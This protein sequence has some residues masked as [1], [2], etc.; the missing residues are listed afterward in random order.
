MPRYAWVNVASEQSAI[1]KSAIL[2]APRVFC[3]APVMQVPETEVI[4]IGPGGAELLRAVLTPGDYVMGRSAECEL[5]FEADLVSRKHAMLTINFEHALV[6]DLGSSN[7]TFVNGQPIKEC[8][9]LWPNQKIQ[10][11]AATVELHR[12]KTVPPPG[13]S[14]APATAAV[15]RILP[16]E[17]LRDKKYDIGGVVARGGMGAILDAKENSTERKVAMKVMLDGST[18]DDLARFIGEAKVT[19]QLEHPNIVPVHELGVDENDQVF[20]TMK[21]VRGITLRK[22]LELMA[23]GTEAT[24]RKYPLAAMLTIFQKVC[25]AVAFA[26]SKSVI[27]RDLKPENIMLGDFG[28]VLVMDWGL[29][30]LLRRDDL[31]GKATDETMRSKVRP[32]PEAGSDGLG[33]V[34]GSIMGTPQ[35][36]APEQARGEVDA[37]DARTDIY[38]LGAI[39]FHLLYLRSPVSGRSAAEIV[40]KVGKGLLD[41]PDA[42]ASAP[43]KLLHLPNRRV[44]DSLLAVC[45]K[46][47]TVD[48]GGR[49][50]S[51]AALQKDI[52]AYQGGFATSAE[53][54]G[55]GKQLV[56]L[57]KRH[58]ALFGT[59]FAAWLVITALA[60]WFV[61]KITASE[62]QERDTLAQLRATAPTFLDQARVLTGQGKLP[63]A[64]D[65]IG[66]ALTLDPNEAG[67]HAQRGNILQSM[68]RFLEAADAYA[69]A[70]RLNPQ[71]PNAGANI[72]LSCALAEAKDKDGALSLNT[73][74]KWRDA[75]TV[76]GRAAEAILDGRGTGFDAKKML[77]VWQAKIDA[78]L[79]K[80]APRL[81]LDSSGFYNLDL[82]NL[83]LTDL[84]P[85]RGMPLSSLLITG[86]PHLK[87][88]SPLADC[89]LEQLTASQIPDL[90]D[91]SPLKGKKLKTL[92]L[93][94]TGVRN[95]EIL[96]GIKT[97]EQFS[98]SGL[99][100]S[101]LKPLGQ[102]RLRIVT[103]STTAVRSLEP[104]RGQPL[105]D[106]SLI[107]TPIASLDP[108]GDA[109]LAHLDITHCGHLDIAA[110]RTRHL[111]E[112]LARDTT[113]D[114]LEVLGEMTE[115][116]III[117]PKNLTDFDILRK[118]PHLR[119]IDTDF[120]GG[121]D[122]EK[123]K[124]AAEFW[125]E[126]DANHG[127]KK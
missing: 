79:G 91:L 106:V 27:H 102:A 50:Q 11:G 37:L 25:D 45:R 62:R 24:T 105:V 9:R 8:T 2:V 73:R 59:A 54:A 70:I 41:W 119:K 120:A 52:A 19:A 84:S 78:W 57:V 44:P 76:Q 18:S 47:L 103:L 114:H 5:R 53:N 31:V 117:L 35:Y 61:V 100:I 66:F 42:K 98:I 68:E 4:V 67:F 60:V 65:K 85:L 69:T 23:A 72:E 15:R 16:E 1:E 51:V 26:H 30:K 87:D 97:L 14:L 17:F 38:A 122:I 32:V 127:A 12:V 101:D 82:S 110:L 95:L 21:F 28:E 123:V 111:R 22:V 48:P 90:V 77:P 10:L 7:G 75:L 126:Y 55:V 58:N 108:I 71:E 40:D 125:R 92:K 107:Q 49:Y 6:E 86:N 34:D 83:S 96:A 88:L 43:M 81:H 99:S 20:Y 29:A 13:V 63:E 116:E 36:M 46:A 109:Q 56:L 115:L 113:L 94:N 112:L 80:N 64:L 93:G 89:P 121:Q 74:M 39:L 3:Y 104:L 33:T 118:L 124:D